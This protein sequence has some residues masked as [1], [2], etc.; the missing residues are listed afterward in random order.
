MEDSLQLD[1]VNTANF[2]KPTFKREV[3][4][5]S[6][7]EYHSDFPDYHPGV[8]VPTLRSLVDRFLPDFTGMQLEYF[9]AFGRQGVPVIKKYMEREGYNF[10]LDGAQLQ[11]RIEANKKAIEQK[12]G[13]VC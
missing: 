8:A 7:L 6:I 5:L 4:L 9:C 13:S 2:A 1:K 10:N 3:I 11:A 12:L